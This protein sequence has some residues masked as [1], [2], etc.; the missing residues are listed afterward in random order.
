MLHTAPPYIHTMKQRYLN[1]LGTDRSVTTSSDYAEI[2]AFCD[3]FSG[4]AT[5]ENYHSL[6]LR[7]PTLL[8]LNNGTEKRSRRQ[9]YKVRRSQLA[10]AHRETQS[11]IP[12]HGVD[13]WSL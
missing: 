13:F 2:Y 11:S 12:D 9:L 10:G 6:P 5:H 8:T 1:C 7:V 4:C 3:V